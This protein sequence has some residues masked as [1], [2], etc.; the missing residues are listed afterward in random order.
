M[1]KTDNTG[2]S[3]SA[4]KSVLRKVQFEFSAPDA[5]HVHLVGD[6]NHWNSQ[7]NLMKKD[8]KG[9]WKAT[10][11][12]RPGRFGYRFFVDGNWE[13]DPSCSDCVPNEF[14]STNCVRN[15]E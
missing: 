10:L 6:F 14:G 9:I 5:K 8:K 3:K 4:G 12:L 13:N 11:S 1:V 2:N 15:V 7:A